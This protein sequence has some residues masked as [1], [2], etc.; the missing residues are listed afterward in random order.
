MLFGAAPTPVKSVLWSEKAA[1]TGAYSRL[2]IS[3]PW[4]IVFF[5]RERKG[6]LVESAGYKGAKR[7]RKAV[8]I[9]KPRC[10]AK[11]AVKR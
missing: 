9:S 5:E 6:R 1:N 8:N 7:G 3:L 2:Y 10:A 11:T 4:Y